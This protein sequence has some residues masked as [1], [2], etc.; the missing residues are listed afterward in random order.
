M[1]VKITAILEMAVFYAAY[2]G[3]MF[4]QKR[5]G[6]TTNQTRWAYLAMKWN[7]IDS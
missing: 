4:S 6:V 1:I 3:K 7:L 5:Q 2:M